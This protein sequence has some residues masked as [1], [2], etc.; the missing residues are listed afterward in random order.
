MSSEEEDVRIRQWE[1]VPSLASSFP[2][3]PETS[4]TSSLAKHS[5]KT[6]AQSQGSKD[7][8][9]QSTSQIRHQQA[10]HP[11]HK[12]RGHLP[13]PPSLTLSVFNSDLPLRTRALALLSSLTINMFLPFVNGVMLGFG[14]IFARTI[15]APMFGWRPTVGVASVGIRAADAPRR[16]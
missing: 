15:I 8:S 9:L 10:S 2:S 7:R 6:G 14:E 16:R 11:G 5:P 12:T 1:E 4:E 13:T 3:L